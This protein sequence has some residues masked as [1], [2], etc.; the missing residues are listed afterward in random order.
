MPPP[1]AAFRRS[2]DGAP[3]CRLLG[4]CAGRAQ[5]AVGLFQV[6]PDEPVET[7]PGGGCPDQ[8]VLSDQAQILGRLGRRQVGLDDARVDDI[9]RVE[10]LDG[11]GLSAP[12][13]RWPAPEA[14]RT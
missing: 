1:E 11:A 9:Q 4:R 2:A 3:G 14:A 6:S 13:E 12:V 7:A 5:R 10:V 8:D